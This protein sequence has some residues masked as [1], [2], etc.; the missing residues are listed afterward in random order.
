MKKLEH[1]ASIL[2]LAAVL[3][4]AACSGGEDGTAAGEDAPEAA[5]GEAVFEGDF[6]S[7]DTSEWQEEESVAPGDAEEEQE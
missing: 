5:S 4:T 6:E 2:W 7:G 1:W 3:A